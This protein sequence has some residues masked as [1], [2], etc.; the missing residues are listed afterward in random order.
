MEYARVTCCGANAVNNGNPAPTP[1]ATMIN[2]KI[3]CAPGAFLSTT[4]ADTKRAYQQWLLVPSQGKKVE[5]KRRNACDR[6]LTAK[7]YNA[8]K[9]IDPAP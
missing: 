2:E 9:A 5:L 3:D 6:K 7:N 4:A 1:S 8:G